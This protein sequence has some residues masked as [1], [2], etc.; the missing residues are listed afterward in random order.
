MGGARSIADASAMTEP[1]APIPAHPPVIARKPSRA[2]SKPHL[3]AKVRN[4]A[5]A[6]TAKR[7]LKGI[8]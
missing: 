5:K 7:A 4:Y 6:P 8:R 1:A 2:G 3:H